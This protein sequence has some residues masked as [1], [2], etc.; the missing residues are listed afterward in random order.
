MFSSEDEMRMLEEEEQR[1]TQ[2]M[3]DLTNIIGELKKNKEVNE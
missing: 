3:D 1:L 2:D